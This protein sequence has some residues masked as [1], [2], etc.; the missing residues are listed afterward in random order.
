MQCVS[1]EMGF[2]ALENRVHVHNLRAPVRHLLGLDHTE[3]TFCNQECIFR[4]MDVHGEEVNPLL[5]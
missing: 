4:L 1:E 3:L 5:A 2:T